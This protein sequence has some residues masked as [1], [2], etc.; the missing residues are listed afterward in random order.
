MGVINTCSN[1]ADLKKL[2]KFFAAGLFNKVDTQTYK[3]E[4]P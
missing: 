3:E 2:R 1:F 4:V